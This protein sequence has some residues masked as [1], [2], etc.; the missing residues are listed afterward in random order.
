[1]LPSI[2]AT[3]TMLYYGDRVVAVKTEALAVTVIVVH[4]NLVFEVVVV[5]VITVKGE[6]VVDVI[7]VIAVRIYMAVVLM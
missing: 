6:M 3:K 2:A 5:V 4:D 7:A 1:M